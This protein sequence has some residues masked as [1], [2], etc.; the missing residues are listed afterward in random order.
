[1]WTRS[2]LFTVPL[3]LLLTLLAVA[4]TRQLS[5]RSRRKMM[6]ALLFFFV[7]SEFLKQAIA[8]CT[9]T[10]TSAYYPFHYSTT[11]Y[12]SIL[13]L[14]SKTPRLQRLGACT[15]FVGGALLFLCVILA[16][17]AILGDSATLF[18]TWFSV[19]GFF[20]HFFVLFSFFTLLYH[21]EYRPAR[22]DVWRYFAFLLA[23]GAIALPAARHYRANYAGLL[24]SFL[25]PLEHLRLTFGERV[26]LSAYAAL[27]LI[28]AA[29]CI[30]G[31]A[32]YQKRRKKH[33]CR[34]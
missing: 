6:R 7:L 13:L 5:K 3:F 27:V 2:L 32:I 20:Y 30:K 18:S 34:H 28:F 31:L 22:H 33:P 4:S 23:W 29:L 21:N 9:N 12:L 14:T 10:H 11:Y 16:P 8:I 1:M 24:Q 15:L 25:P 26:Y 19:H 17:R